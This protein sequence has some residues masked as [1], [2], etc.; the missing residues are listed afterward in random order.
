MP[1]SHSVTKNKVDVI[2]TELRDTQG[3]GDREREGKKGT[4]LTVKSNI[5]VRSGKKQFKTLF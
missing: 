2:Q 3:L 5:Y 1:I 4:G